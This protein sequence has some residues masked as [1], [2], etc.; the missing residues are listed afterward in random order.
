MLTIYR[1]YDHDNFPQKWVPVGFQYLQVAMNL[2]LFFQGYMD[3]SRYLI[4]GLKPRFLLMYLPLYFNVRTWN[5]RFRQQVSQIDLVVNWNQMKDD[6]ISRH[7]RV[8]NR[9]GDVEWV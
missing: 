4:T 1:N 9:N 7:L 2:A 5:F 3:M 8:M 6:N